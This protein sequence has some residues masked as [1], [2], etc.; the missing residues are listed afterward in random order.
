MVSSQFHFNG[1][2]PNMLYF[3]YFIFNFSS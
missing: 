3:F 1:F 2:L